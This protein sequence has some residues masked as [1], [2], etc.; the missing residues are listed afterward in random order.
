MAVRTWTG[1]TI[2]NVAA[3]VQALFQAGA[4][5]TEISTSLVHN[6]DT[7]DGSVDTLISQVLVDAAVVKGVAGA[8]DLDA[9]MGNQ[10]GDLTITKGMGFSLLRAKDMSAKVDFT[11]PVLLTCDEGWWVEIINFDS[12]YN[13]D[14]VG[15]T[16]STPALTKGQCIKLIWDGEDWGFIK[17]TWTVEARK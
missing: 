14:V 17:T 9:G 15:L 13:V 12:T 2:D 3:L 4:T 10:T 7:G 5:E 16:T 11:L 1:K 6:H 8:A